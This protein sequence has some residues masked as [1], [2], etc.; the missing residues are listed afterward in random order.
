MFEST[1]KLLILVE[2]DDDGEEAKL[3]MYMRLHDYISYT[4]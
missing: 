1:T 2:E 4:I 3:N